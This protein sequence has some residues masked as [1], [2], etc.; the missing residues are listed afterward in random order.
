MILCVK[1]PRIIANTNND[2][3]N[4]IKATF[5]EYKSNLSFHPPLQQSSITIIPELPCFPKMGFSPMF[6]VS[7]KPHSNTLCWHKHTNTAVLTDALFFPKCLEGD[8]NDKT[9]RCLVQPH[10]G[11]GGH[12]PDSSISELLIT[13]QNYRF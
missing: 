11:R 5:C 8:E 2:L 3:I 6:T 1:A 9:L 13:T 7:Y 12:K 4:T 10:A